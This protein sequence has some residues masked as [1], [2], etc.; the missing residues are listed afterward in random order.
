MAHF[1]DASGL[2]SASCFEESLVDPFV[3]WAREGACVLLTVELDRPSA[4]E[5]PRVTVRGAR[6]L[7]SV[8]SA[9]R[10][11]LECEVSRVEA[12]ADLAM[13]LPRASDARGEVRVHL[14]TGR[15]REPWAILGQDFRLDSEVIDRLIPIEG[16]ANVA[17]TA[18]PDRHLRL[19]E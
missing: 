18:R 12:V 8:T 1:S 15:G 2:F 6:P 5:P 10:M 17:L 9:A 13:L 16:L 19:V 7:A 3:Q 14:R 11:V 4:D